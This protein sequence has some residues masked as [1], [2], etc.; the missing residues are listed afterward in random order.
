MEHKTC[1]IERVINAFRAYPTFQ[2][3]YFSDL[4][5]YALEA[6]HIHIYLENANTTFKVKQEASSNV[7]ESLQ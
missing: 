5:D 3:E 6:L 1:D 4:N 7:V 2:I